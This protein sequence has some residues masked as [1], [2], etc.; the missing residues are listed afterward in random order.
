MLIEQIKRDQK[1]TEESQAKLDV[2]RLRG[3][4]EVMAQPQGEFIEPDM[5]IDVRNQDAMELLKN[6]AAKYSRYA[7]SPFD[8][9]GNKIRFYP[10]GVTIWSGY[11]GAGKTTILRQMA[12]HLLHAK[13]GV[14]F[15]SLEEDPRDLLLRLGAC[16]F[17]YPL[18]DNLEGFDLRPIARKLQ[19]FIDFYADSLRLWGRIGNARNR[20]ILAV[21]QQLAKQGMTHAFIDSLMCLD[22]ANDD[23]EAQRRFANMVAGTARACGVHIHL[24]AHPRKVVSADQEPDINDVG[25]AREIVGI[26]DNVMFIRRGKPT[27]AMGMGLTPMGVSIK[28]QRHG[29]GQLGEITG[30][31]NQHMRQFKLDELDQRPTQYL[32]KVAYED[33]A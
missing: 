7:T 1:R 11:P 23:N 4:G 6:Y 3:L 33:C 22:V 10:G 5:L 13:H 26:A 17:G 19:W 27:G 29:S 16:A 12:C 21:I 20:D 2:A 25:G 32:P 18:P 31:I 9:A 15:A 28:K 30:W 8:E 24:V 14:F